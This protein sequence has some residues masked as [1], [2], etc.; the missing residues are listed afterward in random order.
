MPHINLAE[1]KAKFLKPTTIQNSPKSSSNSDLIAEL[2]SA[3]FSAT[4][5]KTKRKPKDE[6]KENEEEKAQEG[7]K[8]FWKELQAISRMSPKRR[9][10]PKV[11]IK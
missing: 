2:K 5:K 1:I 7:T 10:P 11:S 4:L 6:N 9:P 8:H 3:N